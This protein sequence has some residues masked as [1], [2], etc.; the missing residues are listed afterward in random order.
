[1]PQPQKGLFYKMDRTIMH[2]SEA[3]TVPESLSIP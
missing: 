1:M 2:G 3:I